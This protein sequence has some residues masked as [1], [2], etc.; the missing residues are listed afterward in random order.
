[1][2]RK[3]VHLILGEDEYARREKVDEIIASILSPDE[4]TY[5]LTRYTVSEL[6]NDV[7]G[8]MKILPFFATK[9]V[10]VIS[11]IA[12]CKRKERELLLS[13][14]TQPS[15]STY[16]ILEG[17]SFDGKDSLTRSLKEQCTIHTLKRDSGAHLEHAVHSYLKRENR[18]ITADALQLLLERVG[19]S[20]SFLTAAL[21]KVVM[22]AENGGTITEENFERIKDIIQAVVNQKK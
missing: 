20:H 15:T 10:V 12:K 3:N 16:I 21:N 1:M 11:N 6:N 5:A 18:K 2:P 4:Q 7:I 17:D 8:R 19:G 14:L 13:Y 22:S 9:Q